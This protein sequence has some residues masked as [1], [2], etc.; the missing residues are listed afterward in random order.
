MIGLFGAKI[1]KEK[2]RRLRQPDQPVPVAAGIIIGVGNVQMTF[3]DNF[4]LGGIVL[5]TIVAGR[6]YHLAKALAPANCAA[7]PTGP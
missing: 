2:R 3:T 7:G 1:W 4:S 5:G 6:A